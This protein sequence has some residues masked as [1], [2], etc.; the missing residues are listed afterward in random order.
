M[1]LIKHALMVVGNSSSGIYEA[2]YLGTSTIDVGIRQLGRRAP[3][4]VAHCDAKVDVILAKMVSVHADGFPATQMI[5][6]DGSAS[7]R[8]LELIMSYVDD[9]PSRKSTDVF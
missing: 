9:L 7:I 4:S 3:T 6:G 1:S 5:Y 8:I 2:P